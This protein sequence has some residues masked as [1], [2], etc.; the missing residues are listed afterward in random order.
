M[1]KKIKCGGYT[2]KNGVLLR[3]PTRRFRMP[4]NMPDKMKTPYPVFDD[5]TLVFFGTVGGYESAC[6]TVGEAN[7]I[8]EEQWKRQFFERYKK[9]DEIY[10]LGE[11]AEDLPRFIRPIVR[12]KRNK[13][14]SKFIKE[15]CRGA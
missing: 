8:R 14:L 10:A 4:D 7:A 9:L 6:D 11:F 5:S 13:L 1:A 3:H 15:N 12:R 2:L